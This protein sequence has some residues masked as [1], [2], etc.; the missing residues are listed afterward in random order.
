[1]K[2]LANKST[3]ETRPAQRELLSPVP[4]HRE[5]P[6]RWPILLKVLASLALLLAIAGLLKFI[7][8]HLYVISS[9]QDSITLLLIVLLGLYQPLAIGEQLR[10][11][12]TAAPYKYS[13][14]GR[15]LLLYPS[16][17][18]A[19]AKPGLAL[20]FMP[21]LAAALLYYSLHDPLSGWPMPR[22][23]RVFG[24]LGALI[25]TVSCVEI[26]DEWRYR[27]RQLLLQRQAR[28]PARHQLPERGAARQSWCGDGTALTARLAALAVLAI[29]PWFT[30]NLLMEADWRTIA[31]CLGPVAVL[32]GLFISQRRRWSYC[33][34]D[35]C[36]YVERWRFSGGKFHWREEGRW[37]AGDFIGIY[38]QGSYH[39]QLWL[40]ARAGNDALLPAVGNLWQGNN[41]EAARNLALRLSAVSGLPILYRWPVPPREVFK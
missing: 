14:A 1:M 34:T 6:S 20:L 31:I 39:S 36:F 41:E 4:F 12:P 24:V 25:C 32:A 5:A 17:V 9:L 22:L 2:I 18:R 16:A 19:L 40:A 35:D 7:L 30:A 29:F 33:P 13:A 8:S 15:R 21:P 23:V 28:N 37:P 3:N 27:W 10:S 11:W 26:L 38:W